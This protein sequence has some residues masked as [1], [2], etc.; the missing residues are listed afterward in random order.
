MV[1]RIVLLDCNFCNSTAAA[2][3]LFFGETKKTIAHNTIVMEKFL[4]VS[5]YSFKVKMT[6]FL[7]AS[8]V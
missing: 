6:C 4:I 7:P 8:L 1:N 3:V 5:T 2:K